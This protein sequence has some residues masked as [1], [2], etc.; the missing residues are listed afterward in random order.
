MIL[1]IILREELT[2]EY[3]QCITFVEARGLISV[4]RRRKSPAVSPP[5]SSAGRKTTRCLIGNWR[6]RSVRCERRKGAARSHRRQD[7]E[8]QDKQVTYFHGRAKST[9]TCP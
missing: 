1:L 4:A 7:C 6:R 9:R 8:R 2:S 3:G 5:T